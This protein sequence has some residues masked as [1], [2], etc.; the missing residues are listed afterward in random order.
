MVPV[1]DTNRDFLPRAD[2]EANR[3]GPREREQEEERG[4]LTCAPA[5]GADGLQEGALDADQPAPFPDVVGAQPGEAAE[6][7]PHHGR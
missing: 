6:E 4:E 1:W 3:V 5:G 7:L 2:S